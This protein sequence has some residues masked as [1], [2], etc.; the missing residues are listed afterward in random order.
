LDGI[1]MGLP[2]FSGWDGAV[3]VLTKG[4]GMDGVFEI[5][6]LTVGAGEELTTGKATNGSMLGKTVADKPGTH[7]RTR[8]VANP[9][10]INRACNLISLSRSTA[11][12]QNQTQCLD[13]LKIFIISTC[14]GD[15][16]IPASNQQ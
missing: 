13:E 3:G 2:K 10:E 12:W 14:Y 4:S 5:T 15:D 8:A 11:I 6:L 7:R 1:V 16:Q 9:I